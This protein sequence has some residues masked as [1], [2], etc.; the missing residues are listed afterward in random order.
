MINAMKLVTRNRGSRFVLFV[1]VLI[2]GFV[3]LGPP[4]REPRLTTA[5]TRLLQALEDVNRLKEQVRSLE[6]RVSNTPQVS[7]QGDATK[8]EVLDARI[9][10]VRDA[11]H[12]R[13]DTIEASVHRQLTRSAPK[14][15]KKGATKK[16]SSSSSD[17]AGHNALNYNWRGVDC[18]KQHA[19]QRPIPR[20][21]MQQWSDPTDQRAMTARRIWSSTHPC[22]QYVVLNNTE[23]WDYLNTRWPDMLPYFQDASNVGER[24]DLVR[25]LWMYDHGGIYADLDAF[26]L[27]SLDPLLGNNRTLVVG[28]E[29]DFKTEKLRNDWLSGAMQSAT[30][31]CF[32]TSRHN[33]VLWKV[34]ELVTRRLQGPLEVEAL[35]EGRVAGDIGTIRTLHRTGPVPFS[36]VTLADPR[37]TVIGVLGLQGGHGYGQ[38]YYDMM[39]PSS[40]LQNIPPHVMN[41]VY[42]IH[43]NTG[44]W[45]SHASFYGPPGHVSEV[46]QGTCL[47]EHTILDVTLDDKSKL[48]Q[49]PTTWSYPIDIPPEVKDLTSLS[50]IIRNGIFVVDGDIPVLVVQR[51]N[52]EME[53]K[54]FY[55]QRIA[56]DVRAAVK[57]LRADKHVSKEH[58]DFMSNPSNAVTWCK[59][60]MT[61]LV[62]QLIRRQLPAK[63]SAHEPW[64][65]PFVDAMLAEY[66]SPATTFP[67]AYSILLSSMPSTNYEH[68]HV[69][70]AFTLE[71]HSMMRRVLMCIDSTTSCIAH[72]GGETVVEGDRHALCARSLTSATY[73][74][75]VGDCISDVRIRQR[76]NSSSDGDM[77]CVEQVQFTTRRGTVSSWY[78]QPNTVGANVVETASAA[79][80]GMCLNNLWGGVER[81]SFNVWFA[82]TK[83]NDRLIGL[84][85]SFGPPLPV[86]DYER[87]KLCM[88]DDG[89]VKVFGRGREKWR[90]GGGLLKSMR[91]LVGSTSKKASLV[92]FRDRLSVVQLPNAHDRTAKLFSEVRAGMKN[93]ATTTYH[94]VQADVKRNQG[95]RF[96][97]QK[98]GI[99]LVSGEGMLPGRPT[100]IHFNMIY[101]QLN[102]LYRVVNTTLPTEV[103]LMTEGDYP[104]G[105]S[106][107]FPLVRF[108]TLATTSIRDWYDVRLPGNFFVGTMSYSTKILAVLAS[109]FEE[110]ILL[111]GDNFAIIDPRLMF[112][113]PLYKQT[114]HLMWCDAQPRFLNNKTIPRLGLREHPDEVELHSDGG[115][116]AMSR[117]LYLP[118]L[119]AIF[120]IAL[121]LG[122]TEEH[123]YGD[124]DLWRVAFMF[125]HQ[126]AT[127]EPYH[128]PGEFRHV[129]PFPSWFGDY[130]FAPSSHNWRRRFH[131]RG[132][133]QLMSPTDKQPAFMHFSGGAKLMMLRAATMGFKRPNHYSHFYRIT[134]A[135]HQI[136]KDLPPMQDLGW[137]TESPFVVDNI[138]PMPLWIQIK[139]NWLMDRLNESLALY[140]VDNV[141]AFISHH[142]VT[143]ELNGCFK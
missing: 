125:Q 36:Q 21:I 33:P 79:P 85:A 70:S 77:G 137:C 138:L 9:R 32:A 13:V 117:K 3:W 66:T 65:F 63:E 142:T 90:G 97:P 131:I 116:I 19:E 94:A 127:S 14:A 16:P 133:A 103:W 8:L 76:T 60:H 73:T 143:G 132:Y 72:V 96:F 120:H 134:E 4:T 68:T 124:K 26:A 2:V 113:H 10:S 75:P 99:V 89:V 115:Q 15:V 87:S 57:T 18:A 126:A 80:K 48:R 37:T 50:V 53:I 110:V 39:R 122:E 123:F 62:C 38:R 54:A 140:P 34:I 25:Y 95:H 136:H 47:D 67:T 58:A 7:H 88:E 45:L 100:G 30:L 11:I 64:A 128:V 92:L 22:Y 86:T 1:A 55:D 91:G 112:E 101:A 105:L 24:S 109:D 98:Q 20:I 49:F 42:A 108:R 82:F 35:M 71:G 44:T 74:V 83:P 12:T 40:L 84:G 41:P 139:M 93:V 61:H 17:V 107:D 141:D 119:A 59:D 5:E 27:Q 31:H 118:G 29:A 56:Q 52:M 69:T 6:G 102:W 130:D 51:T 135:K 104:V 81:P 106:M 121:T 129:S 111:D 114:G 43:I 46:G 28:L 78:G 23:I